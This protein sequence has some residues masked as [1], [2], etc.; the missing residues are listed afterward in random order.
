MRKAEREH[1]SRIAS[2][3]CIVCRN[4]GYGETPAEIHHVRSGQGM[5]QRADNYSSIPLCHPHHRTGGHGVAIHA[6]KRTWESNF[7][8]ERSLLKQMNAEL[9]VDV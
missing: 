5:S 6:G 3:G 9:G 4:L 2:T 8:T 7:G 1:L